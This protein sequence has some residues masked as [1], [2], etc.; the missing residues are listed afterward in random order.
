MT[1]NADQVEALG[2]VGAFLDASCVYWDVLGNNS[3]DVHVGR[4]LYRP[5]CL[6][7]G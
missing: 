6:Q 5:T 7:M 4:D 3:R 1:L 2:A